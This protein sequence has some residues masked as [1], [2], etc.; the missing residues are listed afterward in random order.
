MVLEGYGKDNVY[1]VKKLHVLRH[2]EELHNK[3]LEVMTV[4]KK[5]AERPQ[6]SYKEQIK[7]DIRFKTFKDLK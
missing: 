1:G 2:P 7:C 5:T 6:N 3:V 4:E